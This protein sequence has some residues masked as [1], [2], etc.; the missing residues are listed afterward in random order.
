MHPQKKLQN[1]LEN[2]LYTP[3]AH[4]FEAYTLEWEFHTPRSGGAE[5]NRGTYAEHFSAIA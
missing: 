3:T 5:M 1:F 2:H 4:T